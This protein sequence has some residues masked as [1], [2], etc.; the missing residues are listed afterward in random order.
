MRSAGEASVD[1][2]LKGA[3]FD[4]NNKTKGAQLA[5]GQKEFDY[6]EFLRLE[7][8]ENQPTMLDQMAIMGVGN[9]VGGMSGKRGA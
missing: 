2:N 6:A 5:M 3:E 7:E 9:Y 4:M 8:A 1:A